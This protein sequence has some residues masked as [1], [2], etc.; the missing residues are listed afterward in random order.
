VKIEYLYVDFGSIS[1]LGRI[2]APPAYSQ[3]LDTSFD[4]TAQI[5]RAGFNYRF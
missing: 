2:T 3:G 1:V 4:L 5:V